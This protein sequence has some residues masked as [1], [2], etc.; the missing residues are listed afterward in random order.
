MELKGEMEKRDVK[1]N[2]KEGTCEGRQKK[3]EE[4]KAAGKGGMWR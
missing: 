1:E 4:D 2:V 3:T